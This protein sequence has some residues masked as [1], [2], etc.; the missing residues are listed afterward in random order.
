VVSNING[1]DRSKT[2]GGRNK[3]NSKLGILVRSIFLIL[4]V[5]GAAGV[6]SVYLL[7]SANDAFGFSKEDKAIELTIKS[8]MNV[9]DI[10]L[11]L[12]DRGV[13]EQPFTFRMYTKLRNREGIYQA[14]DYVLNSNMS[15][16]QIIL[17][18]RTGQTIK[19]EV[20]ITFFEGMTIREIARE[21]EKNRVC[22]A[23]SF[24]EG[25]ENFEFGLEFEDM[26][27][28]N[29]LRFRKLEGY[30]FPD[31][32]DFYIGERVDSVAKKFFINFQNKIISDIYEKIR[33]KGMTLDEAVILASIIQKEA[34]NPNEMARVA[35]VFINRMENPNAGLPRLQSDVTIFY[36][37][38]DIKPFQTHSTQ[39]IYDA[40]NTYVCDGLPVGPICSPGLDAIKAVIEPAET[41]YYFFVTDTGGKFYYSKTLNEH[42]ANV[43]KAQSAGGIKHGTTLS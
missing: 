31:T 19:E 5:I 4:L 9:N 28:S 42:Y 30:L 40:Y 33:N 2:D 24:I 35:S 23:K 10:A 41:D 17:V 27:P 12:S 20:K 38:Q 16:D 25:L 36:V 39:E 22:T 21:L 29:P 32:Y 13:I 26:I 18:L 7:N 6:L 1:I 34:G 43:R 3:K 15:Y 14:G 8:G 11:L 37:E